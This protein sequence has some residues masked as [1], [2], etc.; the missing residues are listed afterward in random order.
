[1]VKRFIQELLGTF[2]LVFMGTTAAV[3]TGSAI[4]TA[5]AFGLA[6]VAASYIFGGHFN[7]AVS[8]AKWIKKEIDLKE[9]GI[10]A[11]AQIVGALLGSLVLFIFLG[12]SAGP[13][14][15]GANAISGAFAA[16]DLG[17]VVALLAET[18]LTFI[19][20]ATILAVTKS[21]NNH[22]ALVI[23]LVLVGVVI[24]GFGITGTS[25]NPARSLAPALLVGGTPL[26]QVWL[27]VV[28]P[29]LGA[30]LAA[31]LDNFLEKE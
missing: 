17:V 18:I 15:L 4:T 9:F 11:V 21:D 22:A 5:F 16:A 2:V 26:E 14:G 10:F 24:V 6:V 3:L 1:M 30:G 27:F 31:L 12:D 19:F 8:F 7:P 29:L 13:S 20:V 23:G 28:G 25:V